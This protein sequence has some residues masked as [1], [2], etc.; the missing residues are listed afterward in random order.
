MRMRE[1][2]PFRLPR[3]SPGS[4]WLRPARRR[5][6]DVS[7]KASTPA[8]V[9]V[10]FVYA[11][12]SKERAWVFSRSVRASLARL[13]GCGL[14]LPPPLPGIGPVRF[15]LSRWA[16]LHGPSHIVR[17]IAKLLERFIRLGILF[18]MKD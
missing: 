11:R 8:A 2:Q 15:A 6:T 3:R 7:Y 4:F 5:A 18:D 10:V 14:G 9:V 17:T 1:D 16:S 12:G 13:P